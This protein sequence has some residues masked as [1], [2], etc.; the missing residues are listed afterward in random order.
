MT[1]FRRC[2][3][4]SILPSVFLLTPAPRGQAAPRYLRTN[5][6][7]YLPGD[8]KVAIAFSDDDLSAL[9][10][11]LIDS[12]TGETA[13]GP[14][15]MGADAGSYCAFSHN[16]RLDFSA[17]TGCGTYQAELNDGSAESYYFLISPNAYEGTQE[18][19]LEYLRSQ[20]CGY[21]PFL[22]A[23]CHTHPESATD[24]DA[25]K[26]DAGAFA[27]MSGG[28]H[29]AGDY[30]KFLL[31]VSNVLDL[32]LFTYRENRGKFAD[33]YRADGTPDSNGIPD[34]L[35]EARYG[36][37]W[38]L[39]LKAVPGRLYYQAGG[40]EDHSSGWRLPQ[41]DNTN[42][43]YS[44]YRPAYQGIGA[45]I[46]G[47]SAAAFAMAYLIWKNDLGDDAYAA[48]CWSAATELY[49]LAW[50]NLTARDSYPSWFYDETFFYDDLELAGV[51]MYKASGDFNY[52]SDAVYC[53]SLAG[54]SWGWFD[55]GNIQSLAHY[56]LYPHADYSTQ[57]QLQ[58][59]LRQD[60]ESNLNQA[61]TNPFR[62][63]T[64]Y[65]WGSA[66]VM[67]G[68]VVMCDFYR[69][70][71]PQDTTYAALHDEVRDYL[72]GKNQWGVSWVVGQGDNYARDPHSQVSDIT[73][74]DI[75]GTCIEGPMAQ[76][77]WDGMG[78]SLKDPDEY[79][80]FQSG[81]AVYHDDVNDWATNE[82]TIWQASLTLC[83]LSNLAPPTPNMTP[84]PT[85][86]TPT[87][88]P[89]PFGDK[90][91]PPSPTPSVT[92]TPSRTPTTTPPPPVP[93][94]APPHT[95]TAVPATPTPA[96]TTPT[97]VPPTP[98][99]GS[100][101]PPWIY[102]YD[103]DG[104]SDITIFRGSSGLWAVRGISRVYF[105]SSSDLPVPGDYSGDKTTDIGIF[106]G[107]SGLWA[108]R[109]VTRQYFGSST[110]Q[111]LPGDYN[112]DGSWDI[113]IFRGGSGL[114]AIHGL[115]RIYFGT[116][117]DE[118]VPGYYNGD[119]TEDIGIFRPSSGLWALRGISRI[120]FGGS[121]DTVV[122]GD[123]DG[124]ATWET[125]IF[126]SSS[127]LWAVRDVTRVYFGASSDRPLPADYSGDAIDDVGI[128]RPTSGLWAARGITRVYYGTSGDIPV[129]R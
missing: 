51:E 18:E 104:T 127:G 23:T 119:G 118:P 98:T 68:T 81:A 94:T 91:P 21:N 29:D 20:R 14:Q 44:G 54:S 46:A 2:F 115:T 4:C 28:W 97:P 13:F 38:V 31:T 121:S 49:S 106:R 73:G 87:P 1:F 7:G 108:I 89:T 93:P 85:P 61:L 88:T 76:S 111:A 110:D 48:A 45:N 65:D 40:E 19:I 30:I 120:Y 37:D 66:A 99:P 34:I 74:I 117:N 129:T 33:D 9:S 105:G 92:P 27:D 101:A 17:F 5:Q 10:Y 128:F 8:T 71:F 103:G 107:S 77:T 43:G 24:G 41:N 67:T 15:G 16:Y 64:I 47:R 12:A 102:D 126:C 56:E 57:S 123:Y 62:V 109:G 100:D 122:P 42:Y 113:A 53:S 84:T 83:M 72:L 11:R 63:S 25:W 125:G 59:Y 50:S 78:I 26:V 79:A 52:L 75:H 55:W 116:L 6:R 86:I 35:D 112:G 82:P 3:I 58:L 70:L 39:K 96:P 69:K 80:A 124:D 22:D 36:L 95:P 114:W 32:M 60:L 90:T